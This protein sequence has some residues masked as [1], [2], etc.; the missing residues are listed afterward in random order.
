MTT[1]D[2]SIVRATVYYDDETGTV[3]HVHRIAAASGDDLT[4]ERI[5]Q[6][7]AAFAEYVERRQGRRLPTITVDDEQLQDPEATLRVDVAARSL[8]RD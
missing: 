8:I 4:E 2:L 6:E 3:Q 7:V 1:P 5:E